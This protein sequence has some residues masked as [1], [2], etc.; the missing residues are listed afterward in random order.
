MG[1]WSFI[2]KDLY[3]LNPNSFF[4]HSRGTT[5]ILLRTDAI[6][7]RLRVSFSNFSINFSNIFIDLQRNLVSE[8]GEVKNGLKRDLV[9]V[10][11]QVYYDSLASIA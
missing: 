10:D 9:A 4:F 6:L 2:Y 11:K 7:L 8:N 5:V 1:S 3:F